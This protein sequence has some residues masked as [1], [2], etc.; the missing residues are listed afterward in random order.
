MRDKQTR[1][2][3][4]SAMILQNLFKEKINKEI[5]DAPDICFEKRWVEVLN[6]A[7]EV[8]YKISSIHNSEQSNFK[9]KKITKTTKIDE[10]EEFFKKEVVTKLKNDY[11]VDNWIAEI[12]NKVTSKIQKYDKYCEN[13]AIE[14]GSLCLYLQFYG[15]LY[16]IPD[17]FTKFK[18]KSGDPF[19]LE[20]MET[21]INEAKLTV[22]GTLL[23]F[24]DE[25]NSDILKINNLKKFQ[26]MLKKTKVLNT[27][28]SVIVINPV[29]NSGAN[30]SY[31]VSIHSNEKYFKILHC[32]IN[33]L[34]T[35]LLGVK[36]GKYENYD[37]GQINIKTLEAMSIEH[38]NKRAIKPRD[39]IE[40]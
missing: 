15:T 7:P 28:D 18:H 39:E 22:D 1:E 9:L 13:T 35:N 26:E 30:S 17:E 11:N 20:A 34:S 10:N 24:G 12:N 2:E 29:N 8:L 27:Y 25:N 16:W 36:I 38:K 32:D 37:D 6:I 3:K 23:K 5:V 14:K 4:I 21:G 31:R 40:H 33:L 19:N